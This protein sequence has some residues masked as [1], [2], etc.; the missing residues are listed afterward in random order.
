MIRFLFLLFLLLPI[1]AEGIGQLTKPIVIENALRGEEVEETLILFNSEEKDTIYTLSASGEIG[2]WTSFYKDSDAE[3]EEQIKE[4]EV[5][6]RSKENV[7]VKFQIPE[8]APNGTYKGIITVGTKG[9]E[10]QKQGEVSVQ[11]QVSRDVSIVVTDKE[12]MDLSAS[13]IP[14]KYGIKKGEPLKIKIIYENKGNIS[15]KPDVQLSISNG[16]NQ[17]FNAIFPYSYEQKPVRPR[18]RKEVFIEW[19]SQGQ[20]NGTYKADVKILLGGEVLKE[21]GFRF[22]IGFDMSQLLGFVAKIGGG[23]IVRGWFGVSAIILGL[24][25]LLLFL[26]G[27]QGLVRNKTFKNFNFKI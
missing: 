19:Q 9:E 26:F 8:D 4:I 17:I 22:Q 12:I 7:R 21:S 2:E 18:T 11:L 14:L 20:E 16:Q 27:K 6:V 15:L 25:A 13:I 1:S 24:G 10:G 23:N 5:P 3:T